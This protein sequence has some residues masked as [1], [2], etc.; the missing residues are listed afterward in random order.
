MF[1]FLLSI[2]K[3]LTVKPDSALKPDLYLNNSTD[4]HEIA[5]NLNWSQ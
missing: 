5:P 3:C 4:I 1:F 2:K